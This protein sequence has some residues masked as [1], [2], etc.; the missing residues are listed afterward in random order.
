ME[1][2]AWLAERR[3]A[4]VAAYDADAPTYDQDDYPAE[5]QH[6]WVARLLATCP[7]GGVV[8]DA[9]CGT[10]RYFS[11]VAA[12]G[13]RVVGVDQSNGM[14]DQA[15]ARDIA[16]SLHLISL[17]ELPFV[18]EFD[19]VMTIDAMENVFPEEWPLVLSR[20]HRSVRPGGQIYLTVEEKDE[21]YVDARFRGLAER[22]LPAVRGE[23]VEGSE[24][25]GYHY[26]PGRDQVLAWL[27]AEGLEVVDET[28][29]QHN[30][31]G[32]RHF[33]LR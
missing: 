28:Y 23:I 15:R 24:V 7:P 26:Y 12:A 17:H 16:S 5:T 33:L 19:A 20:L 8:L 21:E 14:L 18:G 1:R 25:A 10:G 4:L 31:W 22:G 2:S 3:A 32:Y 29:V 27:G 13:L 9:P 6:E 30:G 11:M